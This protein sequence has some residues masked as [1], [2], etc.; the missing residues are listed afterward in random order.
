[1]LLLPLLQCVVPSTS[2]SQDCCNM[3]DSPGR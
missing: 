1:L 3:T 2:P